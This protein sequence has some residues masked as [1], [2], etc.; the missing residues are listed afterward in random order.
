MTRRP[1][2][3]FAIVMSLIGAYAVIRVSTRAVAQQAATSREAH[4]IDAS[5][6]VPGYR[7]RLELR[8]SYPEARPGARG[9]RAMVHSPAASG[10]EPLGGR[11]SFDVMRDGE[12][13]ASKQVADLVAKRLAADG[14]PT[15]LARAEFWL[16]ARDPKYLT[17]SYRDR[18]SLLRRIGLPTDLFPFFEA[19]SASER[20]SAGARIA[21]EAPPLVRVVDEAVAAGRSENDVVAAARALRFAFRATQPGYRVVTE[22]GEHE[23]GW[24]RLQASAGSYYEGPGDG[25]CLDLFQQ[26]LG[27]LPDARFVISV[28]RKHAG[29]LLETLRGW[30]AP[31]GKDTSVIIEDLP[32]SQ[33]AQ[34]NGKP[35]TVRLPGQ[36]DSAATPFTLVPRYASRGEEASIFVAGDSFACEGVAETGLAFAQSPLLFQGGNLLAV[37]DAASQKRVLLAGEAEILRNVSLGLTPAQVEDALRIEFGV[38]EV[39]VLPAVSYHVDYEVAVRN[40][41]GRPVALVNDELAAAREIVRLGLERLSRSVEM[42]SFPPAARGAIEQS[43]A[44]LE[45]SDDRAAA[46]AASDCLERLA[47]KSGQWPLDLVRAFGHSP[48]ESAVGNFQLFTTAVDSLRASD[49][50]EDAYPGADH[51]SAFYRSLIR[52]RAQ[53]Q[54]LVRGLE[55]LGWEVV[56][57][58]SLADSEQSLCYL[59]GIQAPRRYLMPAYGGMYA[60]LDSQ[61]ASAVSRAWGVA[62]QI[63]LIRCGESLRR[64]GGVHCSASVYPRGG[65]LPAAEPGLESRN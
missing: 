16:A 34:D 18:E 10:A 49:D 30:T 22:S 13:A 7:D 39:V 63:D 3:V 45:R 33:W 40:V 20:E 46:R 59:N 12:T 28:E 60:S 52:R 50:G 48:G 37:W 14:L 64:D 54:E 9:F 58:P 38:D 24:V 44:M 2:Q 4:V 11:W 5:K 36:P 62:V 31:R 25:G 43:L 61:A 27:V 1:L 23:I 53:R 26:L 35:G 56:R 17:V 55:R 32:L 21:G 47:V 42:S 15:T 57:V 6:S 41:D 8:R 29:G 51:A 65:P 19:D